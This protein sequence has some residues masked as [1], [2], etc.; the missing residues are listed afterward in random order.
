MRY[1][2]G[3][4]FTVIVDSREKKSSIINYLEKCNIPYS[5][6]KLAVGDYSLYLRDKDGNT[7]HCGNKFALERKASLD[8]IIQ[9]MA[10]KE[11]RRRFINELNHANSLGAKLEIFI[12]DEQWYSKILSHNYFSKT[13]VKAIRGYMAYF[14][15]EYNFTLT[16][17]PKEC[18]G[19]YVVDRLIFFAKDFIK[20]EQRRGVKYV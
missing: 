3:Y 11:H 7:I 18:S 14:Q 13:P 6:E 2:D 17:I 10:R 4:E 16:G 9:N 15:Q 20:N 1:I 5:V 12:E 8:E 19:A